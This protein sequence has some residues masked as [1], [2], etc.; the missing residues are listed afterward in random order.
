MCICFVPNVFLSTID[1]VFL[2]TFDNVFLSTID[3]FGRHCPGNRVSVGSLD[4]GA[5]ST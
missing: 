2:S 3:K 1:N 4:S 5:F